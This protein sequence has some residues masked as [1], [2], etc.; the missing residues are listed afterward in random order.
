MYS[1]EL[2]IYTKEVIFEDGAFVIFKDEKM[3]ELG[4]DAITF[5]VDE[6]NIPKLKGKEITFD[7]PDDYTNIENYTFVYKN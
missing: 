3:R 6:T 2:N 5:L 7:S 1:T 4:N